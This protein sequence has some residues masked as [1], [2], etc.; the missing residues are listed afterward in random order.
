MRR[1]CSK[2]KAASLLPMRTPRFVGSGPKVGLMPSVGVREYSR[3]MLTGRDS[4]N[5]RE[6]QR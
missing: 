6:V 4:P 5:A 2:T 1:R 3:S